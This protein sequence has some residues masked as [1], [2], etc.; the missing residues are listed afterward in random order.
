MSVLGFVPFAPCAKCGTE[1]Q[2]HHAIRHTDGR[3]FCAVC[4]PLICDDCGCETPDVLRR[5]IGKAL[6][7]AC[8]ATYPGRAWMIAQVPVDAA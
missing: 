4:R 7:T 6:C 5:T 1:T 3:L 8:C 2:D